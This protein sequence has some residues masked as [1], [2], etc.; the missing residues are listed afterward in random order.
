ML[1]NFYVELLSCSVVYSRR[2]VDSSGCVVQVIES[3]QCMG[4]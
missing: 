4:L 3:G 1:H 2:V